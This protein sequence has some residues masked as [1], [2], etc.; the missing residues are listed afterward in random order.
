MRVP[1]VSAK[2]Q[3]E[4]ARLHVQ[5]R[6]RRWR[7]RACSVLTIT[8]PPPHAIE[9]VFGFC[10][11]GANSRRHKGNQ[12]CT[13]VTRPGHRLTRSH[14]L[15]SRT[16]RTAQAPPKV[17]E[18]GEYMTTKPKNNNNMVDLDH[19]TMLGHLESLSRVIFK[20]EISPSTLACPSTDRVSYFDVACLTER[21]FPGISGVRI[22]E[23]LL[24]SEACDNLID[25]AG[26]GKM[27]PLFYAFINGYEEGARWLLEK[28]ADPSVMT[29]YG[30]TAF[31]VACEHMSLSLATQLAK[32]VPPEHLSLYDDNDCNPLTRAIRGGR[33]D[34]AAQLITMGAP[35]DSK[36]CRSSNFSPL[37]FVDRRGAVPSV[38]ELPKVFK[39]LQATGRLRVTTNTNKVESR[40]EHSDELS[41]HAFVRLVWWLH[42][43]YAVRR[44]FLRH[45]L[46]CEVRDSDERPLKNNLL[47]LQNI[48]EARHVIAEYLG[49]VHVEVAWEA[50]VRHFIV[51]RMPPNTI[52]A[53]TPPN[54]DKLEDIQE[55]HKLRA[56][57]NPNLET[58]SALKKEDEQRHS[59]LFAGV[60]TRKDYGNI[61]ELRCLHALQGDDDD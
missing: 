3:L 35:V 4:K 49:V 43:M 23:V 30:T 57:D 44:V 18:L 32:S 61:D 41:M 20:Q 12:R 5:V 8:H 6:E 25:R 40:F 50:M 52:S 29:L 24:R 16:S 56:D 1:N 11:D 45:V 39:E 31:S 28:G 10:V 42:G 7:A 59:E 34:I 33:A 58:L 37:F 27:T 48:D 9:V 36:V 13:P 55:A 54:A 21:Y 51:M 26:P 2:N 19:G 17:P 22:M 60:Q 15:L 47:R 53:N 38:E 14:P 46:G